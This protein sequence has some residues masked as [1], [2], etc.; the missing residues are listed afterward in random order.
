MAYATIRHHA[1]HLKS[2]TL[3]IGGTLL[4]APPHS[5]LNFVA[6]FTPFRTHSETS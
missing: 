6:A 2:P 1:T 4:T 5:Y 3:R